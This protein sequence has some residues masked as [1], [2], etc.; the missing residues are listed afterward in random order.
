M[1]TTI[2]SVKEKLNAS[3]SQLS[4]VSWM[5]SK[6]PGVFFSRDRKLPFSKVISFLLSMEGG[7]LTSELLKYFGC[8]ADIASSS[9]FVQQRS[10]IDDEAFPMLFKL[11]VKKTDTPKLYKGLRIFAADGSDIQIPTNPNHPDS[12]FPGVNGQTAY[13][14]LH[15]DAMYDLLRHTYID[16]S[17]IGQRKVNERNTL[18]SMVD[19]SSIKNVL[20][21]ADRGYEGFNLMAHIQEKHWK[22][23][24]RVQDVL[25]SRG[26]AA[27]LALPDEDEFDLPITLSLTT[28]SSNEVK[29]LCKDR[30]KY[31]YLPSTVSFDYLPK[32]NRKHDPAIFYELHF[33]IVR[34]KITEYTYETVITNLDPLMFPPIE[35]KRLYNMRWGIETSFRELKYTVG[36]LHFHAKKVEHIYQEVFARLIMYNFTELVTSHVIIQ[37]ADCKYAYKANFSAAVHICRQFFLGNVSPPDV[38]ALIRR[39]VSPIRPGRS[40]PRKMTVKHAV[41]FIYRVA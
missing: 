14:M 33:R 21:I 16:A 32:K 4:E 26:I 29:L 1:T 15:L 31:R 41:S 35:L 3:I 19:R 39:H 18:C 13:N 7:S 6:K 8:S 9:A 17:L 36:L 12:Y 20:L 23:L 2:T 10:K 22:F 5:F 28:K 24:I 25:H 11:F 34:F 38:E 40:R 30:N 37:K 27:G